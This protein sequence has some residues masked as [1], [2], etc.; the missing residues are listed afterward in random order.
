MSL[1]RPRR[2]HHFLGEIQFIIQPLKE[3][4]LFLGSEITAF[5]FGE[6]F[7]IFLKKTTSLMYSRSGIIYFDHHFWEDAGSV[8]GGFVVRSPIVL[9]IL[10]DFLIGQ[11]LS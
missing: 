8:N 6:Y 7:G 5:L 3:G 2:P 9:H 11:R 4:L 1:L 10:T